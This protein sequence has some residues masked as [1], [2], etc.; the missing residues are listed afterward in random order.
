[1]SSVMNH[2]YLAISERES[3][4]GIEGCYHS[5]DLA[6]DFCNHQNLFHEDHFYY[7]LALQIDY[8]DNE[9]GFSFEEIDSLVECPFREVYLV[10]ANCH[11]EDVTGEYPVA[12]FSIFEEAKE[13]CDRN[14]GLPFYE[15]LSV[16]SVEVAS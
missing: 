3:R 9:E 10:V 6:S 13:F 1:M 4:V 11:L 14:L 7:P 12:A 15:P 5:L 8:F 2:V 16:K